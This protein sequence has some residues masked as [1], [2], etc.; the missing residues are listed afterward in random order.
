[1]L[2][3]TALNRHAK[4]LY[5]QNLSTVDAFSWLTVDGYDLTAWVLDIEA[6]AAKRLV[7]SQGLVHEEVGF[8]AAEDWVLLLPPDDHKVALE[9]A[10]LPVSFGVY[11]LLVLIHGSRLNVNS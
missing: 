10:R 6:C 5:G 3:Y 9:F 2:V 8:L 7:Q 4:R 1:M 11:S